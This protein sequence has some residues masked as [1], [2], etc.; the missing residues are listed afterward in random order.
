MY[1]T[2]CAVICVLSIRRMVR[3][4][5]GEAETVLWWRMKSVIHTVRDTRT[6]VNGHKAWAVKR[7]MNA[8]GRIDLSW[9]GT[10]H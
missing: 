8:A 5:E 10:F 2:L 9:G 3:V 6:A 4:I 7:S 1:S